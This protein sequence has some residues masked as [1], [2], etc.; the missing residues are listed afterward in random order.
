[1][2]QN[3]DHSI[4]FEALENKYINQLQSMNFPLGFKGLLIAQ[5]YLF[6]SFEYDGVHYPGALIHWFS[7]VGDTPD[8]ETNM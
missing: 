4:L 8:S 7:S 6:F 1:M 5:V 3:P 2:D